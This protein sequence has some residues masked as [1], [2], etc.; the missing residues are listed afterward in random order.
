[1]EIRLTSPLFTYWAIFEKKKLALGAELEAKKLAWGVRS[2]NVSRVNFPGTKDKN[3]EFFAKPSAWCLDAY[4]A[5]GR[6]N[7]FLENG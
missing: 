5:R 2:G 3:T 4:A 7:I 1:M 6:S